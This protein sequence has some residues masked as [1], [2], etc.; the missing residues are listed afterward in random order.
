MTSRAQFVT[1]ADSLE[2]SDSQF[3]VRFVES[4]LC[5]VKRKISARGHALM[6]VK[7]EIIAE[8]VKAAEG[9]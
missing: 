8:D 4:K 3:Y 5:E 2:L 9:A 6:L 1:T 7:I